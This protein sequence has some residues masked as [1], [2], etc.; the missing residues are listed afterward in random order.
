M[1][2]KLYK[3]HYQVDPPSMQVYKI[4]ANSRRIALAL[5]PNCLDVMQMFT[6]VNKTQH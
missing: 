1:D 2:V 4:C 5:S 6:K 3:N